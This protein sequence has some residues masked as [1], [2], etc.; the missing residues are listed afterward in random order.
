MRFHDVF[1]SSRTIANVRRDGGEPLQSAWDQAKG[2]IQGGRRRQLD[3]LGGSEGR[4]EADR[5][6]QR[7]C[8][9]PGINQG[10]FLANLAVVAVIPP[11]WF[12]ETVSI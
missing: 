7:F 2:D 5:G 4:L 9:M 3:R 6:E 1:K 11:W 8:R 12:W 10:W